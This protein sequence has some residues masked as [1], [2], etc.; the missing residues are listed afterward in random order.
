MSFSII[1][2]SRNI[3]NL[4]ACVCAI[5]TSGETARVIVVWDDSAPTDHGPRE[6]ELMNLGV[7]V[8]HSDPP[9]CFARN[10]NIGIRAAGADDVILL[11][12]DALVPPCPGSRPLTRLVAASQSFGLVSSRVTSPAALHHS[13]PAPGCCPGRVGSEEVTDVTRFRMIPFVCVAIRRQ[14]LDAVGLLEERFYGEARVGDPPMI[15][16]VYGG[17]DDDYCYRVRQ[18]GYRLGVLN[19]WVLDHSTL[20]STFRPDGKGRSTAGARQ[21]FFE[22]HGFRMGER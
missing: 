16:E 5:R 10:V 2:P 3:D 7:T 19:S 13:Y 21:R 22:I 4:L 14:V 9:F 8:W 12:D 17:E 1:I 11:N 6:R 18:A 15:E 20:K